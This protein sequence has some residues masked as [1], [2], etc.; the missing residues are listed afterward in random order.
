VEEKQAV[1]QSCLILMP[2]K[3]LARFGRH[4]GSPLFCRS[5]AMAEFQRLKRITQI[6]NKEFVELK[7]GDK[8]K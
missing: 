3:M 8:I 7:D 6:G 2:V 5:C 4:P 1:C